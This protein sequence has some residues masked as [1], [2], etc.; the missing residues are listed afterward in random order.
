MSTVPSPDLARAIL[1]AARTG[2][3]EHGYATLSMRTIARAVGCSV[4]TIYLYYANKD[5]LYS[6]LVDEAVMHLVESYQPAFG[7]EDPVER[8]EAF[9][10]SYVRFAMTYPEQY[11]VMY[12][13]LNLDPAAVSPEAYRRAWK[14]LQDT[15]DALAEA[16]EKGLLHEPAPMEG[17]TFVWAALHGM[18][19]LILA[20][21]V[22]PKADPDRLIDLTVRRTIDAFRCPPRD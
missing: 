14:P 10:R 15:A 3:S 12:L 1:D 4:G 21:Q 8:L 5:A 22:N 7:V 6:A 13:E 11:K 17:A 16:H 2:V 9:C 20:K 18:L 19:S